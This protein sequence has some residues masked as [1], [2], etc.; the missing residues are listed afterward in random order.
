MRIRQVETF[1]TG[2]PLWAQ[3]VMGVVLLVVA[4]GSV[5]GRINRRFGAKVFTKIPPEEIRTNWAHI[6]KYTIAPLFA[7]AYYIYLSFKAP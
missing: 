7:A 3:V 2:T 4:L 5:Y 6:A 1:I